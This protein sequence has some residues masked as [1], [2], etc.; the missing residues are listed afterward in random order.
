METAFIA[1]ILP[2]GA[3]IVGPDRLGSTPGAKGA[4]LLE[5]HIGTRI[6]FVVARVAHAIGPGRYFY[7]GSAHGPGGI[8]ARLRHHFRPEKKPHWHVDR[9]T[10]AADRMQAFT[11]ENG[12][13]CAIVAALLRS[14][15]FRHVLRGFGSSDCTDCRSHLLEPVCAGA[16]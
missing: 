3:M 4:Y 16:A 6:D 10:V 12:S 5:I 1:S 15:R 7:T 2:P 13:E 14:G 8:R 9:L 11:V